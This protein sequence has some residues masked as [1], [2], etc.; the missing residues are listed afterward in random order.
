MNADMLYVALIFVLVGILLLAI[1]AFIIGNIE[2]LIHVIFGS[3]AF[4]FLLIYT[5]YSGIKLLKVGLE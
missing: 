4:L 5:I 3:F 2:N 1:L